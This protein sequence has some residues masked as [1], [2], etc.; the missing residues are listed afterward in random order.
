MGIVNDYINKIINKTKEN[1][2]NNEK[3]WLK[4]YDRMPEHL[5]YYNGSM[6]DIVLDAK[7]KYPNNIAL[8]YFDIKYTYKEFIKNVDAIAIALKKYNIVENECVTICMPNIPEAIFLIYAV[9][10]IGAICNIIHPLATK[11]DIKNA[12]KETDSTIMFAT[13]VSYENVKDLELEN[14]IMCE[15]SNSMNGVMKFLYNLKNKNKMK[16]RSNVKKWHEFLKTDDKVLETHVSRSQA[17]PAVI[18]YSGGTTGKSKGIILSN[19]CFNSISKQCEVVCQEAKAGN[20][21]L[22]ALPIFHGF[23]L[24]VCI[25]VPLSL[26]LKCILVPKID[27]YKINHLIKKKKPNLLPAIPSML[28]AIINNIYLGPNSFKSVKVILSGGDF[29]S[30]ELALRVKD[31]F[32]KCGSTARIQIGYGLSEATAFVSATSESIKSINNIGIPNPDNTIKIFEPFTDIE[33]NFGQVGEIC[34]KGPSVMLG[35]INQDQETAN[36]LRLHYDGDTWLHTGD[37]GF[38][39]EDGVLHY[40]SRLKRM[41]ISNGYN[42]YPLEL[43]EIINKCKY[44]ESSV[45]VGIKHKEK[46]EVAKAVIVLKQEYE[47]T[48]EIEKEIKEYCKNNIVRYA[49]PAQYEFRSSLPTTKIGKID[50]RKLEK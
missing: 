8:E 3:P 42:I 38:M 18:I 17:D 30:E 14:L 39:S 32:K 40:T 43:E 7:D 28:N 21:I 4:Y 11:N 47:L 2:Q 23:G 33:K 10:K 41:I 36:V 29:L 25:H 37:L 34:V 45:V 12:I 1:Q 49:I 26:G 24:C 19:L 16:Y 27:K 46:Q 48:R 15:V 13:D 5:E 31:Y 22:S 20:S 44:V 50:Y 6:Y 9:N 35:Y